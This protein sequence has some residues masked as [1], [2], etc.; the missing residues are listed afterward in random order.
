MKFLT[1]VMFF[2][3]FSLLVSSMVYPIMEGSMILGCA[4]LF[5]SWDWTHR[6]V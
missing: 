5:L 6:Y 4:L 1:I 3:G 2:T